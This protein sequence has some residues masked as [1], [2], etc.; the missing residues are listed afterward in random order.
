MNLNGTAK[1]VAV[2]ALL[3]TAG[4]AVLGFTSTGESAQ[5]AVGGAADPASSTSLRTLAA[6]PRLK[7]QRYVVASAGN[8]ARYFAREQLAGVSFPNDAIGVT[9]GVSGAVV[10]DDAGKLVPAESKIVVDVTQLKSDRDRRDGYVQRR[11]LETEKYPN[12]TLVPKEITGLT[13]PL[14]DSGNAT[15]QLLGDL[16]VKGVTRPTTWQ[17]SARFRGDTVSGTASTSFTFADFQMD[18][19]SVSIV[20]SVQDTLHLQYDFRLVPAG[21]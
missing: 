4:A 14:P 10:I 17:V 18:K 8:E 13:A 5:A 21:E 3:G 19:P 2:L 7:A 15:F 11:T 12:V 6:A 9:K 20:L 1:R 16:T